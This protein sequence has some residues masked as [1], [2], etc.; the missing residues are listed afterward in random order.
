MHASDGDSWL[1]ASDQSKPAGRGTLEQVSAGHE[2][3]PHRERHPHIGRGPDRF[4]K[5]P[6]RRDADDRER[7]PVDA[8]D[9]IQDGAVAPEPAFPVRM[10]ENGDRGL[11]RPALATVGEGMA[12]R[13]LNAQCRE[14]AVRYQRDGRSLRRAA[15][16]VD[17]ERRD[18][19]R[20]QQIHEDVG[21]LA[22][23]LIH[24]IL[25]TADEDELLGMPH[26]KRPEHHRIEQAEHGGSC[27]NAQREGR[28]R[29][30]GEARRSP[31]RAQCIADVTPE[32]FEVGLPADRERLLFHGLEASHFRAGCPGSFPRIPSG[33]DLVGGRG[34]EIRP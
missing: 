9:P 25:G 15:L 3:C 6:L 17:I 27:A 34:V 26:R 1:N 21:L 12:D 10:A 7:S 16:H 32:G 30:D 29:G 8:N 4:S 2:L 11:A 20:R 13:R 33:G 28:Q 14:V 24:R 23:R 18:A 22:E 5:E 19:A 31:Q